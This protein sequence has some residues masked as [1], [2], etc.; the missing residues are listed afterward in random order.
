MGI[1]VFFAVWAKPRPSLA[2]PLGPSLDRPRLTA[3]S[4]EP[5]AEPAEPAVM[6]ASVKVESA[7]PGERA[8]ANLVRWYRAPLAGGLLMFPPSF[9]SEDGQY[10]L[11]LHLN[12]NTNLVEESFNYAKLNAVLVILNLGVGSGVYED[13][14]ADPAAFRLILLRA[15]D[16]MVARGLKNARLRRIGLSGWSSGYGGIL[17]I[18]QHEEFFDRV[19]AVALFDAIH[20]GY[21]PHSK[22]VRPDQF[23][24][25]LRLA[26]KAA[27]GRALFT[28]THSEIET[29]GYHNGRKT[30][31]MLLEAVGV[32]RVPT[33]VEQP[34]PELRTMWGVV[35]NAY[36]R[37]L[38]PLSEAHRGELHV[39]G[40]DGN[41]RNTHMLHLVQM[42]TTALP[43]LIKYWAR[44]R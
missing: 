21:D 25:A 44:E 43:D 23:E 5:A 19:D 10:D 20:C 28:I 22:R 16:V 18:L 41:G 34:L 36:M 17:K 27:E 39:R 40:Y 31:D 1:V 4:A 3:P 29:Y 8:D 12:G 35:P 42:S 24:P 32:P 26:K 30:T 37:P 6:P 33:S 13:R 11:V 38:T 2:T 14:F 9:S 15:Q 7:A